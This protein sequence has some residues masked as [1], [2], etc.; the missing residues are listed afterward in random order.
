MLTTRVLLGRIFAPLVVVLSCA[1][2][3]YAF[4]DE[5]A[6]ETKRCKRGDQAGCALLGSWLLV[7]KSKLDEVNQVP[8]TG[9]RA[10]LATTQTQRA[11]EFAIPGGGGIVPRPTDRNGGDPRR[12]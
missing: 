4:A 8:A 1:T 3:V 2:A 7:D 9:Y 12:W 5:V 6:D 11:E 10:A